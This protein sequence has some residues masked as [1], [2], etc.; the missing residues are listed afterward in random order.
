[1]TTCFLSRSVSYM[2]W[3]N[4]FL[5]CPWCTISTLVWA[6]NTQSTSILMTSDLNEW[7]PTPLFGATNGQRRRRATENCT[8]LETLTPGSAVYIDSSNADAP[9]LFFVDATSNDL[10]TSDLAGCQCE[11]LFEAA[12]QA[13]SGRVTLGIGLFH[14]SSVQ[15]HKGI[16][17]VLEYMS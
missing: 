14:V 15:S 12:S 10:W 9:T 2:N 4:V 7:V 8:C 11:R 3:W 16:Y 17:S 1:M 6:E 13:Q 5:I